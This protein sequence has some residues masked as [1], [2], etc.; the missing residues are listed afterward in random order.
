MSK[1]VS[2][3]AIKIVLQN[4]VYVIDKLNLINVFSTLFEIVVRSQFH[5]ADEAVVSSIL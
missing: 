1:Q 5:C 3:F 2:G 4:L